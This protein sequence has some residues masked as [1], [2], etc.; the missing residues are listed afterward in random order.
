MVIVLKKQK[1]IAASAYQLIFSN[2]KDI[3]NKANR[4]L[5]ALVFHSVQTR[6]FAEDLQARDMAGAALAYDLRS[7][8]HERVWLL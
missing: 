4:S 8:D 3:E 5:A 7:G 6:F 1:T 2:T